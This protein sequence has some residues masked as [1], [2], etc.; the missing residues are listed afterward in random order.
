VIQAYG[1]EVPEP[2]PPDLSIAYGKHER[3]AVDIWRAKGVDK[4]APLVFFVH[5]GAWRAGDK[6]LDTSYWKQSYFPQKGF[7]LASTNYRLVPEA[8]VEQQAED[9][10]NALAVVLERAGDCGIDAKRVVLLGHSAGAHLVCLLGT[11][12]SWLK[13]TGLSFANIAGVIGNDGACYDV[14]MQLANVM[15]DWRSA[16]VEAFGEEPE[17]QRRLSP[18]CQTDGTNAP[19]F[20]LLHMPERPDS[21]I[22][23]ANNLADGV[24][25]TGSRA[26][27]VQVEAQGETAHHELNQ[28]LGKPGH[29]STIAVNQWLDELFGQPAKE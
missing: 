25:N 2:L 28:L 3:H 15:S 6:A 4:P 23:Q 17:R 1:I 19:A 12:E 27:V 9:A 16:F 5:G 29:G 21:G 14:A 22:V 11:D 13:A 7:A 26:G 24:R 20:L 8:T 10:A 18:N